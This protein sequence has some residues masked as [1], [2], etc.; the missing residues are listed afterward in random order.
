VKARWGSA[1]GHEAVLNQQTYLCRFG[2]AVVASDKALSELSPAAHGTPACAVR[3]SRE[4]LPSAPGAS[5]TRWIKRWHFRDG[6]VSLAIGRRHGRY[7]LD[8][9]KLARFEVTADGSDV[10]CHAAPHTDAETL[11]HLLLDQVLPRVFSL[12]SRL[13]L[14]AGAVA[15]PDGAIAFVGD[16][17]WGKSTLCASFAGQGYPLLSDDGL[18]VGLTDNNAAIVT[19]GYAGLRLLPESNRALAI[20]ESPSG[21][22]LMAVNSAKRRITHRKLSFVSDALPLRALFVLTPPNS[23]ALEFVDVNPILQRDAFMTLVRHSFQLDLE[24]P[25]RQ[26]EFFSLVGRHVSAIPTYRL[27]YTRSFDLLPAVRQAVL[28]AAFSECE[29]SWADLVSLAPSRGDE[30]TSPGYA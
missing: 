5:A 13:V 9:P 6:S 30:T 22:T 3:H 15:T 16:T 28:A 19:A 23:A 20:S 25:A 2:D 12:H 24:T 14:H 7:V 21:T 8:F 18:F 4:E 29:E 1:P 11:R 26:R 10:E 17:G 27:S